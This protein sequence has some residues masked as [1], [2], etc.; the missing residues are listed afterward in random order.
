MRA[1][2]YTTNWDGGHVVVRALFHLGRGLLSHGCDVGLYGTRVPSTAELHQEGLGA[3][4]AVV[5]R[6]AFQRAI[7]LLYPTAPRAARFLSGRTSLAFARGLDLLVYVTDGTPPM[8]PA[9]TGIL[10][11][12]CPPPPLDC[13][14]VDSDGKPVRMA[15]REK[16][17]RLRSWSRVWSP[18]ECCSHWARELWG[19]Q[20]EAVPLPT[21]AANRGIRCQRSI[22][23]VCTGSS[24]QMA[25][26]AE[27][28]SNIFGAIQARVGC[29]WTFKVVTQEDVAEDPSIA[30]YSCGGDTGC[31]TC[32]QLT[33]PCLSTLVALM[34]N[35][36]VPLVP[37]VA[38]PREIVRD[39]LSGLVWQDSA[40]L[41]SKTIALMSSPDLLSAY[42]SA[43]RVRADDFSAR[44]FEGR[45][46]ELVRQMQLRAAA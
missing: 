27:R 20:V 26:Q 2:I 8:C 32:A 34:A 44:R 4:R 31:R 16:L 12:P 11:A 43:A 46:E 22:A 6:G 10:I 1:G 36:T 35:G 24:R 14:A 15:D 5:V 25:A 38:V 7:S 21:G 28:F 18:L 39:G 42:S 37:S 9:A 40:G 33:E 19:V 23:A 29:E 3:C 30:W 13:V 41:E 17:A 45:A